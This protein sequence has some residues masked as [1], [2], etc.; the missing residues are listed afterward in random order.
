MPVV[1]G[2]DDHGVDIGALQQPARVRRGKHAAPAGGGHCALQDLRIDVAQSDDAHP[3]HLCE[4]LQMCAALV[5]Q[6]DDA[7]AHGVIGTDR[8]SSHG[9]VRGQQAGTRQHQGVF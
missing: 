7:D 6:A 1:A 2:G 4:L 9:T 5:V 8:C 3:G